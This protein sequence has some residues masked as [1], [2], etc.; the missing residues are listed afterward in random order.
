MCQG[1]STRGT[2]EAIWL[3]RELWD[4]YMVQAEHPSLPVFD[5]RTRALK[6]VPVLPLGAR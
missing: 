1:V 5:A 3:D 2:P 6:N 4:A